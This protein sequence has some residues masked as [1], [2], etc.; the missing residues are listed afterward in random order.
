MN[1]LAPGFRIVVEVE[2]VKLARRGVT[3]PQ[4]RDLI[5]LGVEAD[6]ARIDAQRPRLLRTGAALARLGLV[7]RVR[8][9]GERA[10]RWILTASGLAYARRLALW[11]GAAPHEVRRTLTDLTVRAMADEAAA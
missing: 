4:A 1:P 6:E 10:P 9:E 11:I 7:R 8:V 3:V 5:V 2:D